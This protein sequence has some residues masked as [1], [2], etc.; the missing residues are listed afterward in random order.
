[1]PSVFIVWVTQISEVS[2]FN[3]PSL[4]CL[5]YLTSVLPCLFAHFV[6]SHLSFFL[7]ALS[8][9][10]SILRCLI[11]GTYSKSVA[12]Q[13]RENLG[14]EDH[15]AEGL[16]L[17]RPNTPTPP[18]R[19]PPRTPP[20]LMG[21]EH[22]QGQPNSDPVPGPNKRAMEGLE[23]AEVVRVGTGI[24]KVAGQG[25]GGSGGGVSSYYRPTRR[26]SPR[27]STHNHFDINEHLPWMIVL[28]LLLV[29]VVIVICSVKRSSRVL[30]KG[31]MQDPSSIM[32]KAIQK[33][34]SAP[35]TQV[36]EKWIYY[37]NGQ[38]KPAVSLIYK[39]VINERKNQHIVSW[40]TINLQNSFLAQ[41]LKVSRTVH[42]G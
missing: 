38:G 12:I 23:G 35:P 16:L 4:C 13:L 39:W 9:S 24:S 22:Q 18:N 17:S 20:Q 32:E 5:S 7:L 31:P 3:S 21:H 25:S 36:K 2:E 42:G 34:P 40:A 8:L 30:K 41:I 1:M 6:L 26:G 10:P 33:K 14:G 37:S 11:T 29:L 15:H 28:L 19:D 27:P